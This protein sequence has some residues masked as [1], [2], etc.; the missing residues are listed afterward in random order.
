MTN[1]PKRPK[2]RPRTAIHRTPSQHRQ[3]HHRESGKFTGSKPL[4]LLASL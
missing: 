1:Q 2:L 4:A 3:P